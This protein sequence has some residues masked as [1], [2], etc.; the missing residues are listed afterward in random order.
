MTQFRFLEDE[1]GFSVEVS[2]TPW[3]DEIVVNYVT[4]LVFLT[5]FYSV[6]GFDLEFNFG[7]LELRIRRIRMGIILFIIMT[8]CV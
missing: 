4:K 1:Y 8:C 2:R 5:L 3:L 7:R 6:P